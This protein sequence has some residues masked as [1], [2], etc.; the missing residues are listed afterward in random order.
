MYSR[1]MLRVLGAG[2]SRLQDGDLRDRNTAHGVQEDLRAQGYLFDVHGLHDR[3]YL[4]RQDG[5]SV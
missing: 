2:V 4:L 1:E 5:G 3:R